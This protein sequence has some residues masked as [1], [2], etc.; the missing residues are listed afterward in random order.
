MTKQELIKFYNGLSKE[1][2]TS[3]S[4][5]MSFDEE[6]PEDIYQALENAIDEIDYYVSKLLK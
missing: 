3:Q 1:I 2:S 5:M 4:L 6:Y